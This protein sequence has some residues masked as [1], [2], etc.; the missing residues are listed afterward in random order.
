MVPFRIGVLQLSMEPLEQTVRMA[1]ACDAAGFDVFWL[2][3]AY[4][5]WRK[6]SMEARSST[7]LTAVIARETKRI[8]V[9]WGIISPYTR[10]PVQIAME[11][12]VLQE[13][14]G[15]GRFFL[16]LG[17]S[18]IF[19]KEIGEGEKGKE[20]SPAVVMRESIEIVRAML[21]G[22]EVKYEGKAFS[23]F[24]PA[25]KSDAHSPRG[26]APIYVGATGPVLQRLAGSHSDGLLTAS[27]TTPDFVR[28]SRQNMEEGARKAGKDTA[29]LDLGSV[30]VGSVAT[31]GRNGTEGA[32]EMAAM[33]LAN[34]VQNIRGS[35]DVLLEK[36]GLTF[37]EIRPI[38]EAM[39]QGGRKAAAKKVS[40]DILKKVCPIAGTPEQCIAAI[41][42]Y[43]EA[44]CTNIMLEIWGDDRE[45][46]ARV[47]GEKVL[48][49]FKQKTAHR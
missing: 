13:A 9:G 41:E 45:E 5:W 32:R 43:R 33:Y 21:S 10:H 26:G 37:D 8:I 25:M 28:Y 38:A 7:A 6:H 23:A 34:K 36:A 18:K 27:I 15:P 46:Q 40:D 44:G 22:D 47:F 3:E 39:E 2:A 24:A 42:R 20:A 19:M 1:K 35:A 17:A 4:P 49:H 31:P 48:P 16:G 29:N 12:R 11:A 30:I 14:A